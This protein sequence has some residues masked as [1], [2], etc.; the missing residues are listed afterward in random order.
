MLIITTIVFEQHQSAQWNITH[1]ITSIYQYEK[2]VFIH[3]WNY[4][5]SIIITCKSVS[6]RSHT[7]ITLIMQ[8]RTFSLNSGT[9]NK[10]F[11]TTKC[12]LLNNRERSWISKK[13]IFQNFSEKHCV[14]TLTNRTADLKTAVSWWLFQ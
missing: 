8:I 5:T 3:F 11:E 14:L 13:Y 12:S 10:N 6:K 9:S 2:S 7:F 1:N 4:A